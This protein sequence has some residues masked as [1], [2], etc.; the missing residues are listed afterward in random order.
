M[1][2]EDMDIAMRIRDHLATLQRV[3]LSV[4][5]QWG[6]GGVKWVGDVTTRVFLTR[7]FLAMSRG[8]AATS[9]VVCWMSTPYCCLLASPQAKKH[10]LNQ[11]ASLNGELVNQSI[12]PTKRHHALLARNVTLCDYLLMGAPSTDAECS[13]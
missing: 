12:N 9:W 4:I 8:P 2:D 13:E 5:A 3:S 11:P 7:P 6:V 1:D 10:I